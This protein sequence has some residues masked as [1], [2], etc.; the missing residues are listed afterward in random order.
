MTIETTV[1]ASSDASDDKSVDIDPITLEPLGPITVRLILRRPF[2]FN[3][4][5]IQY[6]HILPSNCV[7]RYN[8]PTL[9]EYLISSGDFRDPVS[10]TPLTSMQLEHLDELIHFHKLTLPSLV[11]RAGNSEYR[12]REQNNNTTRGLEACISEIVV[13]I[14]KVIENPIYRSAD[15]NSLE[16]TCLFSEFE[17]PFQ[18]FKNFNLEASYHALKSWEAFLIGPPK[19]PTSDPLKNMP[20]VLNFL[21]SMTRI[22]ILQALK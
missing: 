1:S 14:I 10:R 18:E 7:I 12:M 3:V 8:L 15:R 22:A 2:P 17:V 6:T 11:S 9:V 16:L 20:V 13:D 4:S 5:E 19:K 21:R